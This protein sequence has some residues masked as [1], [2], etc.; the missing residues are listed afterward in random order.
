MRARTDCPMILQTFLTR[1]PRR[2]LALRLEADGDSARALS[3][4][5]EGLKSEDREMRIAVWTDISN[6]HLQRDELPETLIV[7]A[8][9]PLVG[10]GAVGAAGARSEEHV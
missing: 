7:G 9:V 6:Y 2:T 8:G 4:L 10:V 1:R 3:V 5:K